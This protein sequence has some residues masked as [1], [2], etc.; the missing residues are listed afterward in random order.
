MVGKMFQ[1]DCHQTLDFE[2]SALQNI[3][4][5]QLITLSIFNLL[6]QCAGMFVQIVRDN[7]QQTCAGD[8]QEMDKIE[9]ERE[10]DSDYEIRR[11]KWQKQLCGSTKKV[12]IW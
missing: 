6:L 4:R 12:T 8:R 1:K 9:R 2:R 10:I 11:K 3:R 5:Q 7:V